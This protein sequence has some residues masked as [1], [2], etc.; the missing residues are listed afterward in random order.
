M[1][2]MQYLASAITLDRSIVEVPHVHEA[3]AR[4]ELSMYMSFVLHVGI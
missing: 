2:P 4:L 3:V 1:K